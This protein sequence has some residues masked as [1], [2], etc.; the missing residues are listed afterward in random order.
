M[1]AKQKAFAGIIGDKHI[2][3][4]VA[5]D[6]FHET[7]MIYVAMMVGVAPDEE[8]IADT[9]LFHEA[10]TASFGAPAE[11]DMKCALTIVQTGYSLHRW[12]GERHA[13]ETVEQCFKRAFPEL[14]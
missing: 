6:T 3:G 12:T 1:I 8:P 5:V 10:M 9:P 2:Q 14:P 4:H 11:V 13:W 7:R